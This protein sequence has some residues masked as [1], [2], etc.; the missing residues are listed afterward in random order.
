[1]IKKNLK[2]RYFLSISFNGHN[3]NGWQIQ[4]NALTVQEILNASVSRIFKHEINVVGC[5]RT[6]AGVHA[7]NF[8]AH[9]NLENELNPEKILNYIK[10]LNGSLPWDIKVHDLIPVKPDAHARFDAIERTYRYFISY[11]KDPFFNDFAYFHYQNLDI[12]TMNQAAK[13]LKEYSD[14][15][16]FSKLHTQTKTNICDIKEAKWEIEGQLFIFTITADR[17]LRNMVRA[18]VGT[19]INIGKGKTTMEEFRKIMEAKNRSKA[20]YSVP[21]KGLFL[22][23]IKYPAGI[24][25]NK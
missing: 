11:E 8:Y 14:F 15:T 3:Y 6:D 22:T 20:G 21:A 16:S 17:F 25:L 19:M 4:K 7:K 12:E 5:G 10:K 24:F 18:I 23:E 1:M 2:S 13:I 9:F